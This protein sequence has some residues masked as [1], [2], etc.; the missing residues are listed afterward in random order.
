LAILFAGIA[1]GEAPSYST[2]SICNASNC[3]PGPFA[4]NSA[5][6]LF[7]ANLSF[8]TQSLTSDLIVGGK[9]PTQMGGVGVYVDGSLAPLLFVSPGQINFLIPIT[10]IAGDAKINVVRQGVTGPIVTI[11]LA[12]A[13]P[14]LFN[15]DGGYGIAEDWTAGGSLITTSSPAQGGHIVILFATGLGSVAPRPAS[16]ELAQ[17]ASVITTPGDLTVLLDGTA[18]PQSAILYAGLTPGSA[19]LYQINVLL[20]S[21]LGTDPEVRVSMAGQTSAA[22]CRLAVR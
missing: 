14:Q 20:P 8:N 10:E 19:G 6:S 2:A 4:P 12:S 18:L 11:S 15:M 16:G 3:A 1:R 7:G 21:N 22:G 13:A 9:L 17:Y 5:I